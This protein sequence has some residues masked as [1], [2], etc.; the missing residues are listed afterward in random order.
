MAAL[1]AQRAQLRR[2][3]LLVPFL[4]T[5]PG[6]PLA[7][8]AEELDTTPAQIQKDLDTLMFCGLPGQ[9][10]GD[11]MRE[12]EDG[13]SVMQWLRSAY[14]QDWK[15]LLERLK[16]KLGGLDPR[17]ACCPVRASAGASA[18]HPPPGGHAQ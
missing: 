11:L 3:S 4:L 1:G 12:N 15:N 10:M 2:M 13:V 9:G 6:T 17:C 8:L 5:H 7:R 16:P 14:D 18:V